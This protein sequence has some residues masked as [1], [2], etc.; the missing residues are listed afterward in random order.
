MDLTH[1][2]TNLSLLAAYLF[3]PCFLLYLT[4]LCCISRGVSY[5]SPS[6]LLS[7]VLVIQNDNKKRYQE[8]V[9]LY[10]VSLKKR[11]PI[12]SA[13]CIQLPSCQSR[14]GISDGSDILKNMIVKQ[15][16]PR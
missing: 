7:M 15:C 13:E 11:L 14:I 5:I 6:S 4:S 12:F 2:K 8:C 16:F 10:T 1:S 9:H 3:P